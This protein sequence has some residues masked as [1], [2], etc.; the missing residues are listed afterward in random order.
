[1][2]AGPGNG[3]ELSKAGQISGFTPF[4]EAGDVVR[5]DEIEDFALWETL[6]VIADGIYGVR[7]ATALKLLGIVFAVRSTC[8]CETEHGGTQCVGCGL[9][10]GFEG[11]ARCGNEKDSVQKQFLPSRLSHEQV[12]EVD[13][14]EGT[15]K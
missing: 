1:A 7:R 14:V 13:G 15:A 5:A 4:G 2:F 11:R 10:L 8:E 9:L 12:P 3:N 6:G